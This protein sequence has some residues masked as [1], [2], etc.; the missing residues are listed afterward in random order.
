[1]RGTYKYEEVTNLLNLQE[2]VK[3][4]LVQVLYAHQVVEM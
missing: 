2:Y 1:M 4:V 3:E